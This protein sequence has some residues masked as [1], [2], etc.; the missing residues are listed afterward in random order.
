MLPRQAEVTDMAIIGA[1]ALS[2]FALSQLPV[3]QR[4]AL[5]VT[6]VCVMSVTVVAVG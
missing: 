5:V 2:S 6:V 3:N 4:W 1:F